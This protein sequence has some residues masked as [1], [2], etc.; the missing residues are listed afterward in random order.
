MGSFFVLTHLPE[1]GLLD[2]RQIAALV[3]VAPVACD[4][5]K[6]RGKRFIQG[7]R[8]QLRNVL[9]MCVLVGIR[10]NAIIRAFYQRLLAAGKPKKLAIIACMRKLLTIL[11]AMV[12]NESPWSAAYAEKTA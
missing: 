4:S 2:R 6:F 10:H 3:G 12:K 1:L 8:T 11:N 9:Y 5:G 7:G